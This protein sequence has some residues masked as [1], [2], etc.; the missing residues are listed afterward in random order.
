MT[1][2]ADFLLMFAAAEPRDERLPLALQDDEEPRVSLSLVQRFGVLDGDLG[3]GAGYEDFFDA[4]YGIGLEVDYL[5]PSGMGWSYGPYFSVG[6]EFFTGQEETVGGVRFEADSL[7]IFN[8]LAGFKGIARIDR[9][10]LLEP[11]LGVG[12]SHIFSTDAE[13][14]ATGASFDF[15][16][17]STEIAAESGLRAVFELGGSCKLDFGAGLR[18]RGSAEEGEVP[19]VNPGTM[20]QYFLELGL[21][22]RF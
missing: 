9:R 3:G 14:A 11:R 13:E 1:A 20:V 18:L 15:L 8:V 10:F 4:G 7:K 5:M 12:L 21:G 2:L 19:Q 6:G 17:A 22:L 16:D